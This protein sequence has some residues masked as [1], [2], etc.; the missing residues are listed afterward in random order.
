[1]YS[2]AELSAVSRV[3]ANGE[4]LKLSQLDDELIKHQPNRLWALPPLHPPHAPWYHSRDEFS[5]SLLFRFHALLSAQTEDQNP[6]RPGNEASCFQ[7]VQSIVHVI[8]VRSSSNI[9]RFLCVSVSN[10]SGCLVGRTRLAMHMTFVLCLNLVSVWDPMC[11]CQRW[12]HTKLSVSRSKVT[13]KARAHESTE[14]KTFMHH[15]NT[16]VKAV[17]ADQISARKSTL[18]S[19]L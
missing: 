4:A 18:L 1:M 16:D 15:T 7:D 11:Y 10:R 9:L 6:W 14:G 12:Y 2:R 8:L 13:V 3:S 17:K 5:I 19:V